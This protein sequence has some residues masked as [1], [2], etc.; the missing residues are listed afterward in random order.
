MKRKGK[1]VVAVLRTAELGTGKSVS[2]KRRYSSL[3]TFSARV[4]EV[5]DLGAV[6]KN[7]RK[8]KSR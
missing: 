2:K 5:L 6:G 8:K 4:A 1:N 3:P 7:L